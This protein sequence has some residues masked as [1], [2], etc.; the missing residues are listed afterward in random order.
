MRRVFYIAIFIV[1]CVAGIAL[2]FV[3]LG[4]GRG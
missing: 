3:L 4:L 1:M 2:A